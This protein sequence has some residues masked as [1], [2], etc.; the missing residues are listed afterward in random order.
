LRAPDES[1]RT[2]AT[3]AGPLPVNDPTAF[4]AELPRRFWLR[5]HMTLMLATMI[6]VGLLA[7]HALLAIPVHTMLWRWLI[8][9][10]VSY[11]AFFLSFRLWL[12]YIGVLPILSGMTR[13][14]ADANG[15]SGG[16]GSGL[17]GWTGGGRFSGGGGRFGGAGASGAWDG[18]SPSSSTSLGGGGHGS[19]SGGG[20]GFDVDGDGILVIILG[21]LV[22]V[23]VASILGAAAYL[24]V[25]A[26]K[27]L[28]D[29]AFSI[30]L[31]GGVA[32]SVRR[33]ST[34]DWE[35]SV[36][37]AT[38]KPFAAVVLFT[39]AAGAFAAYAMPGARTLGEV[40]MLYR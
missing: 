20:G 3:A 21:I 15:A 22:L 13:R 11:A 19:G 32:G 7:N 27:V 37:R 38:W 33:A 10:A 4:R 6:G 1:P 34:T 40:L 5:W 31:A 12:A 29:A 8:A 14:Q 2:P 23:L 30:L 17:P 16:N 18:G 24:I 36:L 39:I 9:L 25:M 28:A 35:G 26:P